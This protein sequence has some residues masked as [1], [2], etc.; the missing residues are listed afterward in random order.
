VCCTHHETAP[1]EPLICPRSSPHTT[2]FQFQPRSTARRLT[3]ALPRQRRR[4]PSKTFGAMNTRR[5]GSYSP[6]EA[7]AE[8]RAAPPPFLTKT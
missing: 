2:L 1:H 4:S 7:K 6:A 8:A 5:G 3:L